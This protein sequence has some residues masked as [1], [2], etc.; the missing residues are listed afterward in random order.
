MITV[1][2]W[3]M[4]QKQIVLGLGA[5]FNPWFDPADRESP[6]EPFT[7]RGQGLHKW[8]TLYLFLWFVISIEINPPRNWRNIVHYNRRSI[9]GQP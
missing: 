8:V 9:R 4:K 1:D 2:V 5:S 7:A 3:L 6:G